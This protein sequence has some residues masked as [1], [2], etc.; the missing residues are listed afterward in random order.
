MG[1]GRLKL[2]LG[3]DRD[4]AFGTLGYRHHIARDFFAFADATGGYLFT[5][6]IKGD[7]YFGSIL[8]GLEY[9]W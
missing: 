4:M 1:S 8:G 6:D 5:P 2:G 9:R 3:V 7:R